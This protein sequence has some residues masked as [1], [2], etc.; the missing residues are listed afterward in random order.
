MIV[1]LRYRVCRQRVIGISPNRKCCRKT[2]ISWK[3]KS[4]HSEAN[5]DDRKRDISKIM[6]PTMMRYQESLPTD[7]GTSFCTLVHNPLIVGPS[8]AILSCWSVVVIKL[9][10]AVTPVENWSPAKYDELTVCLRSRRCYGFL[11]HTGTE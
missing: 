2:H 7:W 6:I 5:Q 10:I 3:S 11:P 9:K 1:S 8:V 4:H